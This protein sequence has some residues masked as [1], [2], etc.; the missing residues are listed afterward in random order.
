MGP[1]HSETDMEGLWTFEGTNPPVFIYFHPQGE[2]RILYCDL[3]GD[4]GHWLRKEEWYWSS[5][6]VLIIQ[7]YMG[8]FKSYY[9]TEDGGLSPT[10]WGD[11]QGSLVPINVS[12]LR[13]LL[14]AM[15]P[16][17]ALEDFQALLDH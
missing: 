15:E 4:T 16:N 6:E 7:D 13:E 10:A 17:Q 8:E 12:E 14:E 9:L 1:I 2:C 3:P 11:W 5:A